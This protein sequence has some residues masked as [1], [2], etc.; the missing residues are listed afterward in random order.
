M[1]AGASVTID[2]AG[3][4]E[5]LGAELPNLLDAYADRLR[6]LHV[7]SVDDGCRHVPLTVEHETRYAELLRRCPD[8]P[9]ILEAPLP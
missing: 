3:A 7:S 2:P 9:W 4:L 8:V 6:H 1:S 5:R